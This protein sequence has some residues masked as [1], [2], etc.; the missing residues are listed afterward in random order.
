VGVRA[1]IT[2]VVAALAV[3]IFGP[4]LAGG[5]SLAFRDAGHYYHPLFN[6]IRNEWGAGRLPLWNPY[7][8]CGVPLLA[9][10]TASVFYPGKLLFALP[11][12]FTW[13][14]NLYI[15]LHVVLAV[16]TSYLL[17]RQLRARRAG[18]LVGGIS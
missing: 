10:N 16:A 2:L 5:Q 9:E 15:V 13:L 14:Y 12:S 7:E 4:V 6:Y 1:L 3:W 8:N 11:L 17:A 18:A